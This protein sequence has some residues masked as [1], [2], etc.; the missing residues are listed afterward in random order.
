MTSSLFSD[1]LVID[2]ASFL[3]GPGAGTILSDFGARVIKIEP[4]GIGDGY[5]NLFRVRGSPGDVDYFWALVS[6]NKESLALDLKLPPARRVLETLVKKA[7]VFITNYPAPVR[8]R[9]RVRSEDIRPLNPRLIYASLS[10]YGEAGPERDRIGFDGAAYWA[11]SGMMDLVRPTAEAEPAFS[12]PGMGDLP[13]A[14]SLYAAIVTALYRRQQTGEGS[15]VST[16]LMANG[17]W[18]NGCQ[19]QSALAGYELVG[20]PPRGQRGVFNEW[21]ETQDGRMFVVL[22]THPV[23]DWTLLARAVGRPDWLDDPRL[24]APQGLLDHSAELVDAL[25]AIFASDT[26]ESWR[27]RL[28]AGGVICSIVAQCTDHLGDPQIEANGFF[29]EFTDGLGLRVVDSPFYLEG[30]AKPA[31]RM[32]P[33]IGQHTREILAEV[34]LSEAEIAELTSA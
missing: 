33:D 23:R 24:V 2:C 14:M 18:S 28:D 25:S 9:L 26:W 20:R 11:R 31:P 5:R 32:A 29:P 34:G 13:T 10:P 30:V 7:D 19:V 16:S 8:E 22:S 27:A 4:P 17:L 21:Y 3:A 1:L 15:V 6:R 12:V